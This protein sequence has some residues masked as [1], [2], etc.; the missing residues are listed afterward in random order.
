MSQLSL[1]APLAGTAPV[2]TGFSDE[3]YTPRWWL[4][5]LITILA[6]ARRSYGRAE[7]FDLDVCASKESA[8]A[9]RYYDIYADGLVQPWD[10]WWWCNPPYSNIAPWIVKA[11]LATHPGFMLLPA[12]TDRAW[13]QTQIEPLRDL[14]PRACASAM[15]IEIAFHRRIAF[16]YPGNPECDKAILAEHQRQWKAD[17]VKDAVQG[18]KIYPVLVGFYPRGYG[19]MLGGTVREHWRVIDGEIRA[20]SDGQAGGTVELQTSAII[21]PEAE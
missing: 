15:T 7:G 1:L 12:W 13:W 8:K 17:G 11:M 5:P 16:G 20:R 4:N 6:A 14:G 3:W 19:L 2:P 10:G 9:E 21:L 18:A